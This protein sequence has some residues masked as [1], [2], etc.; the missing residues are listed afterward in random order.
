MSKPCLDVGIHFG[1]DG[2]DRSAE[3]FALEKNK[4]SKPK[5]KQ[6]PDVNYYI[7]LQYSIVHLT[8]LH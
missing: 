3:N 7:N 4:E 6:G 1:K 5:A 2:G 8:W